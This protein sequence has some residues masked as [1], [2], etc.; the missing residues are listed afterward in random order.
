[1]RQTIDSRVPKYNNLIMPTFSALKKLGGSGSNDEILE[2][3]IKDLSLSDDVVDIPHKGNT[4]TGYTSELQYQLAWARTYLKKYGV[5]DNSA[6]SIW[7]ILPGFV[8]V[9]H[10]DES[11]VV[12]AVVKKTTENRKKRLS[13]DTSEHPEDNE[14]ENDELEFPEEVK[15][16]RTKLADIL[17]NMDPYG[18]ER[19]DSVCSENVVSPMLKSQKNL[20]TVELMVLGS[21]RSTVFLVLMWRFNVNDTPVLL[22]QEIYGTFEA[23]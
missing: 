11:A 12:S 2:K 14:A 21:G 8:S 13:K 1:M 22:E 10:L 3:V 7:S 18:F 16:W 5:I 15:P 6:R 20:E 4:N 17:K 19:L 23:L 9:D